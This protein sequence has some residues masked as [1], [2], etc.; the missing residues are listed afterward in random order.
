MDCG[1]PHGGCCSVGEYDR[2]SFGVCLKA[3]SAY[4]GP[5]RGAGDLLDKMI[6]TATNG[7]VTPCGGCNKRKMKLNGLVSF[8]PG[9][10]ER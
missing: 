5:S 10:A 4:D 7:K 8:L 2:P 1:L 6:K 3:C 9:T